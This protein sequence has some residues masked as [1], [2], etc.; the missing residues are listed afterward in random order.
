MQNGTTHRKP[1]TVRTYSPL[2]VLSLLSVL[3]IIGGLT[4]TIIGDADPTKIFTDLAHNLGLMIFKIGVVVGSICGLIY[5]Y[6]WAKGKEP[7]QYEVLKRKNLYPW[8]YGND[9][10]AD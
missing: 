2:L 8:L 3:F 4:I 9:P 6:R 7:K 1:T 10:A 5:L